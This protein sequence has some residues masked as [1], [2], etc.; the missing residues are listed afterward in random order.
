VLPS[1]VGR[2]YGSGFNRT[3]AEI[4]AKLGISPRT[5]EQHLGSTFQKLEIRRRTQLKGLVTESG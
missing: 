4:A 2:G 5:V 1:V 3:K